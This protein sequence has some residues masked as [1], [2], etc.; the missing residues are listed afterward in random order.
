M[1]FSLFYLFHFIDNYLNFSIANFG[2]SN[3]G[4]GKISNVSNAKDYCKNCTYNNIFT[5]SSYQDP[6]GYASLPYKLGYETDINPCP[7]TVTLDQKNIEISVYLFDE[8]TNIVHGNFLQTFPISVYLQYNSLDNVTLTTDNLNQNISSV[9]GSASFSNTNFCG[10]NN[11][12]ISLQFFSSQSSPLFSIQN[13]I[14]SVLLYG[15]SDGY[16]PSDDQVKQTGC[17]TCVKDNQHTV[18]WIVTVVLVAVIITLIL[19]LCIIFGTFFGWYYWYVYFKND[20][21]Y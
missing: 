20:K 16:K 5:P 4:F 8:F 7:G 12:T 6:D 18:T 10:P 19:I 1:F 14:C 2:A 11:S 9:S 17:A 15:C 13:T 21:M 3:V